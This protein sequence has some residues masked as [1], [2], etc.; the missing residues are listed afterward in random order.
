MR[1]SRN[2]KNVYWNCFL[3]YQPAF[4]AQRQNRD[5]SLVRR[6]FTGLPFSLG[7]PAVGAWAGAVC[8]GSF[9]SH[10]CELR[11]LCMVDIRETAP[12]QP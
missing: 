3:V 7:Q 11:A 5:Q 1:S 4:Q 6:G 8:S 12:Q 2:L 10:G 9:L